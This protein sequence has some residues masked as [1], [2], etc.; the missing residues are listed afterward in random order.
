[1]IPTVI[2]TEK[3][4]YKRDIVKSSQPQYS[5]L[6]PLVFSLWLAMLIH[7]S[8]LTQRV[9]GGV[10]DGSIFDSKGHSLTHQGDLNS[11][12]AE[13]KVRIRT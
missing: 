9:S 7:L 8:K 10:C 12:R 6:R 11:R 2:K 3:T 5:I 13:N 1:M 4:F